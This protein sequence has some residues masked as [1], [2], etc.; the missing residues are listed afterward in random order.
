VPRL[1]AFVVNGSRTRNLAQLRARFAAA[2]TDGDWAQPLMLMTTPADSGEGITRQAVQAGATVVFAVGGDG[3]VRAC[4]QALV[5]TAVPLAIVPSGSGN[6]TARS[7]GVPR[8]LDAA[9]AVGLRG[10]DHS[11]DLASVDG[12]VCTAMAGIGVDAAVVATTPD[13]LKRRVGWPAYAAA[14]AV[15]LL[16]A[17]TEFSIRLDD[18]EPLVRQARAVVVGNCGLLPGGFPI[19]PAARPDDGVLDVGILAPSGL[20]GWVSV[21]CRAI[22]G[23]RHDDH[24][25][26]RCQA[27]RVQVR[28][29]TSL[30]R[31]V[32]GEVIAS[33]DELSVRALPDA[34][35]VRVPA[36]QQRRPG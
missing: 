1:V 2:T 13:P 7:L 15:H 17:P 5:G 31:Q 19:L 6:L 34:L 29:A 20:A 18:G 22:L 8:G 35:R 25:L 10:H 33:S 12:M 11:I 28:A 32:D 27:R 36:R 4:A 24:Q 30:P 9:L 23:S 14:A 3:T 16:A 26:Q 21:G